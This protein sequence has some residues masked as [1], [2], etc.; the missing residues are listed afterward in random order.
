[1]LK[2]CNTPIVCLVEQWIEDGVKTLPLNGSQK[3]F[4]QQKIK[5]TK[6]QKMPENSVIRFVE[7]YDQ[8]YEQSVKE[9]H[10]GS[11]SLFLLMY[12]IFPQLTRGYYRE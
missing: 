1:M 2:I 5:I 8:Y 10:S 12:F 11:D 3:I 4:P 6:D 7:M 9:L